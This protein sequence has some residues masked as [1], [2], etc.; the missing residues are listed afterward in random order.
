MHPVVIMAYD[1]SPAI[2]KAVAALE[3]AGMEV[4]VLNTNHAKLAD[5]LGALAGEDD[6][7]ESVPPPTE[8]PASDEEAP[9]AEADPEELPPEDTE[10]DPIAAESFMGT[11]D[12]ESI[13]IKI[14]E[15]SSELVPTG[16]MVGKKTAYAL[17]ETHYAFWPVQSGDGLFDLYHDVQVVIDGKAVFEGVRISQPGEKAVLK[18]NKDVYAKFKSE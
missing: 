10:E 2:N 5:F 6:E 8:E 18:L 14:V 4:R 15:G 9:A 1:K 17:N 12:G 13:M 16:L 7:E 11:V 3:E